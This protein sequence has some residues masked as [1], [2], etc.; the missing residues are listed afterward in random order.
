MKNQKEILDKYIAEKL[1]AQRFDIDEAHWEHALNA[2][3]EEENKPKIWW[4]RLLVL[5]GVL[6]ISIAG[7]LLANKNI[8]PIANNHSAKK[9]SV[10]N[11]VKQ[12]LPTNTA[13][14]REALN[15]EAHNLNTKQIKQQAPNAP[16]KFS[17]TKESNTV[18]LKQ[19]TR[20]NQETNKL[21]LE[22][23]KPNKASTITKENSILKEHIVEENIANIENKT[24]K[25]DE[26]AS[27]KLKEVIKENMVEQ[28]ATNINYLQN[29]KEGNSV[30]IIAAK[31][32]Q[33][34]NLKSIPASNIN[35]NKEILKEQVPKA[36]NKNTEKEF[37]KA[38]KN[39]VGKQVYYKEKTAIVELEQQD[40]Q[41][42]RVIKD[43]K[44]ALLEPANSA[45]KSTEETNKVKSAT[46]KNKKSKKQ[47]V[48]ATIVENTITFKDTINDTDTASKI[49][50][51]EDVVIADKLNNT[52]KVP[53][54]NTLKEPIVDNKQKIKRNKRIFATAQTSI[55]NAPKNNA[56][57]GKTSIA[58]WLGIAYSMPIVN[59]WEVQIGAA[60]TLLNKLNYVYSA[61]QVNYAF[62]NTTQRFSVENK[63][64][65]NAVLPVSFAYQINKQHN[66]QFGVAPQIG[67]DAFSKVKDFTS[68]T[69]VTKMGYSHPYN[70]FNLYLN[71]GYT[72]KVLP[73][74][75]AQINYYPGLTDITNNTF[76][77]NTLVDK[78]NRF[79]FGINY[80]IK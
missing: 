70:I 59:K 5:G 51:V 49:K 45:I 66:L 9:Y 17:S 54:T 78:A 32:F 33:Q 21:S 52:E 27:S 44:A 61:A 67:L 69:T 62:G 30:K 75:D 26:V 11:T 12:E 79:N 15:N 31:E 2:L 24:F 56:G 20:E 22:S 73:F 35:L 40:S 14:N 72:Y 25:V 6:L 18:N 36:A 53:A 58:P 13:I 10:E 3:Q 64:W 77:G 7:W 46:T 39:D 74:I 47:I 19:S 57:I 38:Q 28:Q 43:N 41:P 68:N 16:L 71:I 29:S 50:N 55:A 1:D 76:T 8:K 63:A 37:I 34:S 48:P 4:R 65:L 42:S 80:T 23:N 60:F